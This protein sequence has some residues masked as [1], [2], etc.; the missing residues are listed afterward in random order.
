MGTEILSD[1]ALFGNLRADTFVTENLG[2]V[3]DFRK[4]YDIPAS[5]SLNE[6]LSQ[7]HS[8]SDRHAGGSA[9]GYTRRPASFANSGAFA[10]GVSIS[11]MKIMCC[12]LNTDQ[13]NPATVTR[14]LT[15]ARPIC[16]VRNPVSPSSG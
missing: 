16:Q 10:A 2:L 6:C 5:F 1:P 4:R 14:A 12:A 11:N 13:V 3:A 8:R 9:S 15:K 7:R